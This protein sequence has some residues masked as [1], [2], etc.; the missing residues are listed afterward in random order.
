M[1]LKEKYEDIAVNFI[2]DYDRAN[3][4][5]TNEGWE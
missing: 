5:T 1:L 4:V 3:P 2:D